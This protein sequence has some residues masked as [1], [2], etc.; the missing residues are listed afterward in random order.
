MKKWL[1]RVG[2]GIS[3]LLLVAVSIAVATFLRWRDAITD[4]LEEGST[5]VATPHGP[6]E[7]AVLGQG[8]PILYLHG[9]PGGFDQFYRT[10]RV[11]YG[12]AGPGFGAIIPSRPGYLRTPLST[13]RTPAQQADVM[14][15]LLDVLHIQHVAVVAVSGAGP[16][17]LEFA[18]RHPGRCSAL[19]L[20]SAV[21][22]KI[23]AAEPPLLFRVLPTDFLIWGMVKMF[24]LSVKEE[25]RNDP[26]AVAMTRELGKSAVP[27]AKR[28][29][30]ADNDLA[31]HARLPTWP[32]RDI[33][34]PTLI[35]HGAA[36][37]DVPFSHAEAAHAQIPGSQLVRL[38]GDHLVG[39]TRHKEVD[40]ALRSFLAEHEGPSDSAK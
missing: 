9:T 6:V 20:Q 24:E 22:Q 17:A 30:G 21:T 38:E 35:L 15:A 26:T 25:T 4:Q 11:Q 31:Q 27:Y 33:R 3:A 7:Y 36:D 19:I 32:L 28:E 39:I 8:R 37:V 40:A 18:L 2:L 23:A 5:L 13:G 34:C 14:A 1:K 29:A 12:D 10:L 16:A